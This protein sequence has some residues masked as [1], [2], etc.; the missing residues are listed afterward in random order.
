ML[1]TF[2]D[3]MKPRLP[4]SILIYVN[5]VMQKTLKKILLD[6]RHRLC[7][8]HLDWIVVT[9]VYFEEFTSG[10]NRVMKMKCSTQ[11]FKE[12]L[13]QLIHDCG[14]EKK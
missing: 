1:S 9:S 13:R 4:C 14:L 12:I 11:E 10:F 8:G 6:A 3:A 5:N 7:S 2:L